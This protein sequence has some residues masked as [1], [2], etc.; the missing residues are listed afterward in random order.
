MTAVGISAHQKQTKQYFST[1]LFLLLGLRKTPTN[2]DKV[3]HL[4]PTNQVKDVVSS[5]KYYHSWAN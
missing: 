3:L 5:Y 1:H 2:H 4:S